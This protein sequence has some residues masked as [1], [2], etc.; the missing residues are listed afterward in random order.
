MKNTALK[1]TLLWAPLLAWYLIGFFI[2]RSPK[3]FLTVDTI[4]FSAGKAWLAAQPLYQCEGNG[5]F[6]YF[7]TSAAFFSL[8]SWMPLK[9]AELIFRLLSV[10]M[11]TL[12][13]FAFCKTTDAKHY[14][15]R[16]FF[17]LL[18]TILLTQPA[19][20]NGQCHVLTTGLLL[21]GFASI[22]AQKIW[23]AS[24]F[25]ALA[26]ALKPTSIVLC[27]LAPFIYP[28]LRFQLLATIL[29]IFLL[30]FI[31]FSPSYVLDSY[32]DF[33]R[34]FHEAM[35]FD[36]QNADNWAT[37]FGAIA[38]YS[39]H[40]INGGIQFWIRLLAALLTLALCLYMKKKCSLQHLV[41]F[42]FTLAMCYLML[43]NSRTENNDYM[44]IAPMLGYTLSL[45][46][47]KRRWIPT[48]AM[49]TGIILICANWEL[50]RFITP[51]NNIWISPTVIAF[52]TFYFVL[53]EKPL[54]Q[55]K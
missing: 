10:T 9:L 30:P 40:A 17:A 35:Q 47:C 22:A 11:L 54:C 5:C 33:I 36:A 38:F 6:V 28:K 45:V 27:L 7:P 14:L 42:T 1:I 37:L 12:G 41:F 31:H 25:L 3:Y 46:L 32:I 44:M 49:G 18:A 24:F 48:I 19:L 20:F 21:L 34:R 16:Y 50:T 29:I 13:I 8:F 15:H 52:F 55:K 51:D 53:R 2:T 26:L 39:G 23:R 4:Y 43:F